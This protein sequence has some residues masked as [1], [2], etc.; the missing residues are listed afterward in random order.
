M[1]H[2]LWTGGWDSTYR[3]LDL[4]LIKHETVQTHYIIDSDRKSTQMELHTMQQIRSTVIA[5][6]PET[7]SRFLP[8]ITFERS[9]IPANAE[10]TENFRVITNRAYA[11]TQYDWLCRYAR[12]AGVDGMDLCVERSTDRRNNH[13]YN[14]L[15]CSGDIIPVSDGNDFYYALKP[16]PAHPELQMFRDVRFPLLDK[17]KHQLEQAAIEGG[18]ADL[19]ETNWFCHNPGKDGKP[20]GVCHPCQSVRMEGLGRRLPPLTL[21][22]RITLTKMWLVNYLNDLRR[23]AKNKHHA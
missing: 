13:I 4:L 21:R 18:F 14:V 16:N 1:K 6:Y 8:L 11:G 2:V 17:S 12:H 9:A 23:A 10:I 22:N 3:V 19:L 15:H 20:Y 7:E 5:R